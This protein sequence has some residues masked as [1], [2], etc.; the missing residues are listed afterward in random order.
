MRRG[1]RSLFTHA[2]AEMTFYKVVS[3]QVRLRR[4]LCYRCYS[5]AGCLI[6]GKTAGI[7][8]VICRQLMNFAWWLSDFSH[9]TVW[10]MHP[11][12]AKLCLPK[13]AETR[14]YTLYTSVYMIG[15]CHHLFIICV[16]Y[17]IIIY[18]M[19]WKYP[20][21]LVVSCTDQREICTGEQSVRYDVDVLSWGGA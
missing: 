16:Y 7:V 11:C 1:D 12:H 15:E 21:P 8:L 3:M 19:I 18:W 9:L 17:R 5:C 6:S 4:F 2:D 20:I 14:T 13:M 10:F